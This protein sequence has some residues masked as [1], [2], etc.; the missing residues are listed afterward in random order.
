MGFASWEGGVP[1]AKRGHSAGK[2]VPL[3]THALEKS[4]G[5]TS[6]VIF[7]V[8]GIVVGF[9]LFGSVSF[10]MGLPKNGTRWLAPYQG[11]EHD[12]HLTLRAKPRA[13]FGESP[14]TCHRRERQ[15]S[16]APGRCP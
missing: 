1:V 2:R 8:V 9:V 4:E 6:L 14:L 15:T 5:H 10:C 16:H 12:V 3:A 11:L 13:P 7:T